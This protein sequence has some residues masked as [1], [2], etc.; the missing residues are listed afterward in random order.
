[1]PSSKWIPVVLLGLAAVCLGDEKKKP[2]FEPWSKIGT[3]LEAQPGL[4]TLWRDKKKTK[5]YIEIPDAHLEK[6]FLM[7]TSLSGGTPM[8]GWQWN[9]WLL[10]W[11]RHKKKLVLLQREVRIRAKGEKPLEQAIE[12]TYTDRV[13]A[14][15]RIEGKGKGGGWVLDGE[16]LFARNAR[17]FFGGIGRSKDASLA[18]FDGT[19]NFPEN[20]EVS[21]TLPR[22]GDG[23]LVTL[24]YSLSRLPDNP[25]YKPREADD[26][27]GYFTTVLKDFSEKNEDDRRLV[28]FINRWNLEKANK[29]LDLSPPKVPIKFIIEKTV[30]IRMRRY[31]KEGI[32]EWNKAFEKVGLLDAIE[33][34]Q[35][36]ETNEHKDKD[37]EDIR[38]NFFRWIYSDDPFAMGPSRVDPRTGEILDADIL[39]DDA[40][41]RFTLRQYRLELKEVPAALLPPSDVGLL[42][43][44]PLRRLKL[45]PAPDEFAAIPDDAARPNVRPHAR[46][47]FC[48]IGHGS[49]HQLG[50]CRLWF[51]S[52]DGQKSKEFPEELIGQFVKDTVM[53]EVG[54]TLGLRHNFKSSTFRTY[55]EINSEAKPGDIAGSVMDYNPIV[56]APDGKPQGYYSMRTIGPY[57]YWAIEYGYELDKKKLKKIL[58]RV[59]EKGLDYATDEDTWSNDPYVSRWDLGEDPLQYAKE[60]VALMKRLR[61]NLE[62]RAV[63]E[64]ERYY[65]LRRAINMQLSEARFAGRLAVRFVGGEELHRDHRGDPNARPPV[66]PIPGD[67]QKAA[68]RFVCDEILSG[69]YFEFDPEL[70]RKVAPDYFAGDDPTDPFAWFFGIEHDYRFLDNVL[71]VQMQLVMGLT[72]P[73]RLGRVLDARHKTPEGT[74]VLTAPDVFDA[75]AATIFGDLK[76]AVS[77]P[78]TNQKPAIDAMRRNLQREYVSHLIYILLRNGRYPAT[79]QTLVRHYV[80]ELAATCA[81]ALAAAGGADTYTRAHLEECKTRLERAL[82]ASYTLR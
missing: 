79:I 48:G 46:R 65:R 2:E 33:V 56:I 14:S 15:F 24:H 53:H 54:H 52:T 51:A 17:V 77:R 78:S 42:D 72:A 74:H 68:L 67:K 23:T 18:S 41:I 47:A 1:M 80:K 30:P 3:D 76:G 20:T 13:L 61:K 69:R 44:H 12:Q 50:C 11:R 10:V 19:K 32:L 64:G 71:A 40:Y 39:F 81:D 36:T 4:W 22:A 45:V 31:V 49:R 58:S 55:D 38:Y 57:D 7:A 43:E 63:D 8:R 75:L 60:R 25:S 82:E 5:F 27:I 9:D 66:V 16:D 59:A 34:Q 26:R 6:P 35:Q 28:R 70:L 21:V 37:P 73:S 29:K 62:A